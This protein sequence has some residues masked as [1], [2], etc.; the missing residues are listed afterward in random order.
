MKWS[1]SGARLPEG[2]VRGVIAGRFAAPSPAGA[3]SS[4]GRAGI[5]PSADGGMSG[6]PKRLGSTLD[7]RR[8]RM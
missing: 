7:S 1:T 4:A 5:S 6:M 8:P 2:V 3:S